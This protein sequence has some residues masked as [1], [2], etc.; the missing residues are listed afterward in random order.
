MGS[1]IHARRGI[2]FVVG[3]V[4]G[5]FVD[6]F[7]VHVQELQF[8]G[9]ISPMPYSLQVVRRMLL[10]YIS[11][12]AFSIRSFNFSVLKILSLIYRSP[13][14]IPNLGKL[15]VTHFRCI[16]SYQKHK[17]IARRTKWKSPDKI[18]F[19]ENY[20]AVSYTSDAAD[21]LLCV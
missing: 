20:R 5:R 8:M 17:R 19:S 4:I 2:R 21:D 6:D 10:F 1:E 18:G 7:D 12:R 13:T 9:R 15:K 11:H 16:N 14:Y 3:E